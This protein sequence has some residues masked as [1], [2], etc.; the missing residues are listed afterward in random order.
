MG[1]KKLNIV[2]GKGNVI[3]EENRE[4]I[5]REALLHRI[6][7]VWFC[8]PDKQIIFQ[9]RGPKAETH[10]NLLD[11]T[12]G[13]HVEIGQIDVEAAIAEAEEEVGIRLQKND[14]QRI[15]IKKIGPVRDTATNALYSHLVSVFTYLYKGTVGDLRGEPN[16]DGGIRFEA[17]PIEKLFSLSEEDAKRIIPTLLGPEYF[18]VFKMI[19]ESYGK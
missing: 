18:D 2:D 16:E 1:N 13:G 9:I 17:W 10:P 19:R 6:V 3:G 11:A 4:K 5:H 12:A 14:L 7:N 8:T 15:A